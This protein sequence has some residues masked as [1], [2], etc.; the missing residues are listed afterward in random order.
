MGNLVAKLVTAVVITRVIVSEDA[1]DEEVQAIAKSRLLNNL[2][3]DYEDNIE[4]IKLDLEQPFEKYGDE[5]KYIDVYSSI[6]AETWEKDKEAIMEFSIDDRNYAD[7]DE[8]DYEGDFDVN[9]R[10]Y[11]SDLEDFK[12]YTSSCETQAVEDQD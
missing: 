7:N 1:T 9:I 12:K 11:Q 3:N 4:E 8:N 6:D 5:D 2:E 10:I